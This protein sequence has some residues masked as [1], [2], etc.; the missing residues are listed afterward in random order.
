MLQWE[1]KDSRRKQKCK[2]M[3][4]ICKHFLVLFVLKFMPLVGYS[5]E[6][7]MLYVMF[8]VIWYICIFQPDTSDF[9]KSCLTYTLLSGTT[10]ELQLSSHLSV[11]KLCSLPISRSFAC[12]I[13]IFSNCLGLVPVAGKCFMHWSLHRKQWYNIYKVLLSQTHR[14]IWVIQLSVS[15]VL[16]FS[17]I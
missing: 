15:L 2:I 11:L 16:C 14:S 10:N 7:G 17:L 1:M 4:D 9:S 13:D 6:N 3:F 8:T 5:P 12:V